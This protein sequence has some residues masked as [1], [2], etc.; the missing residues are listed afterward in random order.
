ML[1]LHKDE[2]VIFQELMDDDEKSS[3][4]EVTVRG[5]SIPGHV[6]INR[7]RNAASHRIFV[8]YFTKKSPL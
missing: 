7:D 5:G 8:D 6:V 2:A 4:D 1:A 3:T